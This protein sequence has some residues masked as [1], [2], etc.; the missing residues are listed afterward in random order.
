MLDSS[1]TF[2]VDELNNGTPTD[3]VFTRSEEYLHRTIY[4]GPEHS[5]SDRDTMTVARTQPTRSGNF[6]GTA[7]SSLKFTIDKSVE[8]LEAGTYVTAP[9]I[10]S[11][12]FSMPVG[13]TAADAMILR[14]RLV[15]ALDDEDFIVAL[16]ENLNV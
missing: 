3:H 14:Q 6:R 7:K 9:L 1:I 10:G 15:A 12:N 5:L 16:M 4:T 8:T 11:I 2:P 13:I